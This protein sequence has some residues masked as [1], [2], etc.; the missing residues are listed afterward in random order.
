MEHAVLE[1]WGTRVKSVST[2]LGGWHVLTG[3][4]GELG[5]GISVSTP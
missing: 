1:A 2:A 3:F 5:L 4:L